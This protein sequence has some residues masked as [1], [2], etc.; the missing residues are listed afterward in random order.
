M[1]L[2]GMLHTILSEL[3]I[4]MLVLATGMII[5]WLIAAR[6]RRE[7]IRTLAIIADRTAHVAAIVGLAALVLAALAGLYTTWE[8]EAVQSTV[9]TRNKIVISALSMAFWGMLVYVR[10]RQGEQVWQRPAITG[11]Y[12]ALTLGGFATIVLAG[13]LGGVASLKGTILDPFF[14]ALKLNRYVM[15]VL[16]QPINYSLIVVTLVV[17][18]WS[19][20]V[21]RSGK[22][23]RGKAR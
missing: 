17:T 15:L 19:F 18:A 22:G 9:L 1:E 20:W 7:E 23:D 3:H 11:L 13:S 8:W 2:H 10:A 21:A 5:L 6:S 14:D 4:G 16:P 12:L